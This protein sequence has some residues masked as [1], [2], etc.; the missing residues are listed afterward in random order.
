ML[1]E[2]ILTLMISSSMLIGGPAGLVN[3][4]SRMA[5]SYSQKEQF[6]E[7]YLAG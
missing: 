7:T 4:T 1:R 5:S 2:C 3:N 6:L